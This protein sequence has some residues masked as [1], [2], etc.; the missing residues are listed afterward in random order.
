MI[1]RR[2][3]K[4]T[5]ILILLIGALIAFKART[6]DLPYYWD[7]AWVYAPAV[8]AM[9]TNGPSL[10]PTAIPPELSRGH[11]LMFH[12]LASTWA[13][14][15]GIGRTSMHAFQLVLS[16]IVLVLTYV[17]ARR[18][19]SPIAGLAAAALVVVNELF[20]AQSAILLPEMALTLFM[21]A[22]MLGAL[23]RNALLY[24]A[25]ASAALLTKESALVLPVAVGTLQMLTLL[26]S[27]SKEER[28]EE[29]KWLGIA[30]M[31]VIPAAIFFL[32]QCSSLGWVFYPEHLGM[33]TWDA[34]DIIYKA[35]TIYLRVFEDQGALVLTYAAC[36]GGPLLWRPVPLWRG[37]LT[38]LLLTASIKVLWGR[39]PLPLIPTLPATLLCLG[40]VVFVLLLPAL[41]TSKEPGRVIGLA[42]LF[43]VGYWAFC[44]LNF[45]TDRYLLCMVPMMAIASMTVLH[46]ALA[47]RPP[48]VFRVVTAT[49]ILVPAMR[50]G[51]GPDV[52]DTKLNYAAAIRSQ[53][54]LVGHCEQQRYHDRVFYGSFMD[55]YYMNDTTLGYLSSG[56]TFPLIADTLSP[57]TSLAIIG[58]NTPPEERAM[59][60]AAG[61]RTEVRFGD[62]VAWNELLSRPEAHLSPAHP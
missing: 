5:G 21:L 34:K 45:Y 9:S 3:D 8:K 32:V 50:I 42:Y 37:V 16:C 39:W 26:T 61:F 56:R 49:V 25:F 58:S 59:L 17:L 7:E 31:P 10:S 53:K 47:D 12:A 6:L 33:I 60:H 40:L 46:H 4:H 44:A 41:R 27:S 19:A 1:I 62:V 23:S 2:P 36:F 38:V 29:L 13:M 35:K 54:E 43:L 55:R 51:T 24:I 28:R 48:W 14:V 11:P 15:F 18:F 52:G 22:A 30:L 57:T 20:L